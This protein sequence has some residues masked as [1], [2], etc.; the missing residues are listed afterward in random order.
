MHHYGWGWC[1]R[2]WFLREGRGAG[3][4]MVL[5]GERWDGEICDFIGGWWWFGGGQHF[6]VVYTQGAIERGVFLVDWVLHNCSF[7]SCSQSSNQSICDDEWARGGRAG[8]RCV[9][10]SEVGTKFRE[11]SNF[12]VVSFTERLLGVA[13][14]PKSDVWLSDCP[15]TYIHTH[16]KYTSTI[17]THLLSCYLNL[18][19]A[20]FEEVNRTHWKT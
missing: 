9:F 18:R 10:R 7:V 15:A 14:A 11:D 5:K 8:C 20:R 17:L 4:W 19:L 13:L 12:G 3:G 16:K 1:D 2:R 6:W